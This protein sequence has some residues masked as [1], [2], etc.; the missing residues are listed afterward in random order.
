V[1]NPDP[2]VPAAPQGEPPPAAPAPPVG[3]LGTHQP[4]QFLVRRWE[5]WIV[6]VAGV[7]AAVAL[8]VR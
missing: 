2:D 3:P 7:V 5:L 8:V 6:V 1:G 4:R